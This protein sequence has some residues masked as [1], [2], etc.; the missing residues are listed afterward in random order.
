MTKC[1]ISIPEYFVST[2]G[3]R[4]VQVK[5]NPTLQSYVYRFQPTFSSVSRSN[6]V[7]KHHLQK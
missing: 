7:E 2:R 3:A 4:F 1:L 5:Q 6:N